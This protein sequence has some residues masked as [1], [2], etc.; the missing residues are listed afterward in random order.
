MCPKQVIP[1]MVT[2]TMNLH[3][4]PNVEFE[5]IIFYSFGLWML[6]GGM[7]TFALVSY[8][9]DETWTLKHTTVGLF[10]VHETI[11]NAMVLQQ[12]ALLK[13]LV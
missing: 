12:Q 10:E 6:R 3:V 8:Y 13:K 7:D 9:L 11:G 1:I 2:K 5:T 4:L